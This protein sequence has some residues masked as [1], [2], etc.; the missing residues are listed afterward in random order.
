MQMKAVEELS[1][2]FLDLF[3]AEWQTVLNKIDCNHRQLIVGSR[4]RPQIVLWGY[5]AGV[6]WADD[7]DLHLPTHTAV[8]IE[9]IH[10]ASLLLDD[11]VDDDIAR[12]GETAFHLDFG[13]HF[14]VMTAMKMVA[15]AINRLTNISISKD[16]KLHSINLITNTA[17]SMSSGVLSELSLNTKTLFDLD[18]IKSIA[19]L[20][21]AEIIGDALLLGYIASC[22]DNSNMKAYLK[23]IGNLSG[24]L[25]QTLNDLESFSNAIMN[26]QHKGKENFDVN[27]KRK[28]IVIAYLYSILSEK[29]KTKF[30]NTD[31]KYITILYNKYQIKDLVLRE[32]E[33]V[34]NEIEILVESCKTN[35]ASNEWK[36]GYSHFISLLQKVALQKVTGL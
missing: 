32:M 12:H 31:I 21:T 13:E 11:W 7:Y 22:N 35:G 2:K 28:N 36:N 14:T 1:R 25:F 3:E 26:R 27:R 33:L 9:L 18:H 6:S 23:K 29:E 15:E 10:K 8:S 24:F 16:A 17:L 20:E 34:F 19:Q 30:L 4:L 5:L